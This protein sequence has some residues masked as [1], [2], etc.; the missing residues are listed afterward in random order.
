MPRPTLTRASFI[1]LLFLS[2]MISQVVFAQTVPRKGPSL[3]VV[4]EKPRLGVRIDPRDF[5][6]GVLVSSVTPGSSAD[7]AGIQ[8]GD[9]I[10]SAAG[11][12]IHNLETLRREVTRR[13]IGDTLAIVVRR[14]DRDLS[15]DTSLVAPRPPEEILRDE[16]LG[17]ALPDAAIFSID[18]TNRQALSTREWSG[19]LTLVEFWATWCK[20]CRK[21]SA[22]LEK[23]ARRNP[24]ILRVAALSSESPMHLQAW[25]KKNETGYRVYSDATRA[26]FEKLSIEVLPT[27]IFVDEKG[28]IRGAWVGYR[29]LDQVETFLEVAIRLREHQSPVSR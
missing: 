24:D 12:P 3:R 19:K 13:A 23:L 6:D 27:F 26:L 1:T 8:A 11:K 29:D 7:I 15:V 20:V 9:R 28:I 25:T 2:V 17:R 21:A 22:R 5:G 10:L 14:G 16:W 4:A 18:G